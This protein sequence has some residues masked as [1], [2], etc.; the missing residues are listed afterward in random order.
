VLVESGEAPRFAKTY[1]F[2]SPSAAA[3]VSHGPSANGLLE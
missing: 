1:V 3:A 2:N